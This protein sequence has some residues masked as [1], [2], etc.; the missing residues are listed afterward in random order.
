MRAEQPRRS[1]S[2]CFASPISSLLS[3][4]IPGTGSS[5]PVMGLFTYQPRETTPRAPRKRYHA[6]FALKAFAAARLPLPQAV[7]RYRLYL[8]AADVDGYAHS[9][10][11]F[12]IPHLLS[13]TNFI[14]P[15]SR[16]VPTQTTLHWPRS[17][18]LRLLASISTSAAALPYPMTS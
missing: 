16:I 8:R 17:T 6:S 13:E 7:L 2:S 10:T 1:A 11:S 3:L 5:S 9:L 18:S 14:I 4:Q 15:H 12:D